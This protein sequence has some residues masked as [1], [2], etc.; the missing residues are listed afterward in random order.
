MYTDIALDLPEM[1]VIRRT[2]VTTA[3]TPVDAVV[4]VRMEAN[5]SC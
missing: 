4:T 1:Y 3:G 5:A 2:A